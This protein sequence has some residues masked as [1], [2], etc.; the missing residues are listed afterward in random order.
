[1][2]KIKNKQPPATDDPYPFIPFMAITLNLFYIGAYACILCRRMT[3]RNLISSHSTPI[4]L[5][6]IMDGR[7]FAHYQ[8]SINFNRTDLTEVENIKGSWKREKRGFQ[9]GGKC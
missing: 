8:K 3:V 2:T 7:R 1:M 9:E 5:K 6:L 4:Q